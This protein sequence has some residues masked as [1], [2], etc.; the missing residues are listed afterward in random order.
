MIDFYSVQFLR[1][2]LKSPTCEFGI[3]NMFVSFDWHTVIP[4]CDFTYQINTL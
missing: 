3:S 4:A 1:T 2:W